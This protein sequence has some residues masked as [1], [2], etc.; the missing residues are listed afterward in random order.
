MSI[1]ILNYVYRGNIRACALCS[2]V[3]RSLHGQGELRCFGPSSLWPT[4]EPSTSSLP[5][6]GNDDL[7]SIGFSEPISPA[8]LFDDKGMFKVTFVF[9]S[10]ILA[11]V[12]FITFILYIFGYRELL[13]SPLVCSMVRRGTKG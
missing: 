11:Q 5:L 4:L 1:P 13:G 2:C 7:S 10:L 9:E 3:E 8:S 6:A 12:F